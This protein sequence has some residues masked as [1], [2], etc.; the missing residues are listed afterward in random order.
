MIFLSRINLGI[1]IGQT[2]EEYAEEEYGAEDGMSTGTE[3]EDTDAALE[4]NQE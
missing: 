2:E 3:G 4:E 1:R